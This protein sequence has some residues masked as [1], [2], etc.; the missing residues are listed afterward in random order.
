MFWTNRRRRDGSEQGAAAS[1]RRLR[2]ILVGVSAVG[3]LAVTAPAAFGAV[4]V[5][6]LEGTPDANPATQISILGTPASNIE[7]VTVTGSS[8][9]AHSG[10]LVAYDSSSG[11]SYVL[12]APFSE[13]EEADAAIALKEGGT[14]EDHFTIANV[15]LPEGLIKAEGEK[16]E[17]LEHFKTEPELLPPKVQVNLADPSLKGDFFLDPLPSPTIHVGSKLL[18]F[19]PVGPEGLMLLNPEGKLLWWRQ[20]PKGTVGSLLEKVSYEGQPAIAWWQGSVTE[21]AYGLG[22]GII[23]NTAY[24]PVAHVKAGNGLQMD[25]HELNVTPEGQA[26]IDAVQPTCDPVCDAEHPPV[27][28]YTAQEI[29]I[30]TGMVMWEWSPLGHIPLSETEVE[31]ANGAF[32]PYHMNTVEP[33]AG[34]KVLISLRDTSGVYLLDQEDGHII[35]Q[36]AGKKTSFTRK[37]NT[38]FYFQ[39]DAR[40]EGKHLQTLTLFDDEAG[41]PVHGT[42]RGLVLHLGDGTVGLKHQYPRSFGTIAGSEGSMR[43]LKQHYAMVGFGSTPYFSEFSRSGESE[44]RGKLVFDAQLPKGDGTYRVLREEW[45]GTPNTLPKLV[46]ERESISEVALYASWNGAT[47]VASWRVLGGESAES[48][49]ALGT[50]PWS[51]FETKMAV[52]ST[53]TAY[54]VQALDSSGH[55]LASSGPVSTP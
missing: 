23:A 2:T 38:Q 30:K 45:E 52:E 41:P 53:D 6:P 48:L 44:K 51:G 12:D 11:A 27:L 33:I 36:I 43:V 46:A 54:E 1:R 14:I 13:G 16:P 47:Q 50:Y 28:D 39:H 25:I 31:P 10:H 55:V 37:K 34:G 26:W 8:S 22:E 35:W 42:S 20:L 40:L 24:E 18:E 29:D 17:S 49:T 4:T 7:S 32:D 19:E 15:G 5:S 21:T 9:G 3:A